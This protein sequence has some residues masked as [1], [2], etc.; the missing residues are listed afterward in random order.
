MPRE[1][2]TASSAST[3]TATRDLLLSDT[4][5]GL[6][7]GLVNSGALRRRAVGETGN[8]VVLVVGAGAWISMGAGAVV[9]SAPTQTAAVTGTPSK[10]ASGGES[11]AGAKS[12]L[13]RDL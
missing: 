5:N 12:N 9:E 2:P 8:V 4:M 3:G 7:E 11:C 13:G 6:R 1:A 10:D